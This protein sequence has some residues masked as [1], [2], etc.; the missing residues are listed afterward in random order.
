MFDIAPL[1]SLV[2]IFSLT[3]LYAFAYIEILFVIYRIFYIE[4]HKPS[5][6]LVQSALCISFL[7]L[8]TSYFIRPLTTYRFDL[9]FVSL[10]LFFVSVTLFAM[11]LTVREAWKDKIREMNIK[12]LSVYSLWIIQ[13]IYLI[14][15][16]VSFLL[17]LVSLI[18]FIEIIF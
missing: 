5:D 14:A 2:L 12:L 7:L 15:V 17:A 16:I 4:K 6:K 1:L 3:I 11:G 10:A 9:F 18:Q 13:D 8:L